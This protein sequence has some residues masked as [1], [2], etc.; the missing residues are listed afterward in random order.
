MG[1]SVVLVYTVASPKGVSAVP[2]FFHPKLEEGPGSPWMS[3]TNSSKLLAVGRGA[4]EGVHW[5]FVSV[6][7][8]PAIVV[9]IVEFVQISIRRLKYVYFW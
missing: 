8:S 7:F 4:A 9:V 3:I 1:T 5:L 6:S 2:D